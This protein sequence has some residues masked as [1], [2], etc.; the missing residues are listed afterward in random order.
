MKLTSTIMSSFM[1]RGLDFGSV[2]NHYRNFRP[3]YPEMLFEKIIEAVPSE[4]RDVAMDLGA[5]TGLSTTPRLRWFNRVIA[6][7]PDLR[8]ASYIDKQNAK[9]VLFNTTA[10]EHVQNIASIDLITSGNAFYWMDCARTILNIAAWLRENGVLAAHCCI[11]IR[12]C[13]GVF[14]SLQTTIAR[15]SSILLI[16]LGY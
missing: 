5:G 9:V 14:H 7:E 3:Q 15:R 13:L 2:R 1:G 6:I 16:I 10:E 4:M 12:E 11:N 8:M